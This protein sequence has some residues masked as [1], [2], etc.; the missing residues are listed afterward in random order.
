MNGRFFALLLV[1]SSQEKPI[2]RKKKNTVMLYVP[3]N[4]VSKKGKRKMAIRCNC[5]SP[6]SGEIPETWTFFPASLGGIGFGV[7]GWVGLFE[8]TGRR[9]DRFNAPCWELTYPLKSPF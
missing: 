8:G 1:F 7:F 5:G 6:C 4:V 9:F 2:V 3:W